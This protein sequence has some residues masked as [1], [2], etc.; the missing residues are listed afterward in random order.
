MISSAKRYGH[1]RNHKFKIYIKN[2]FLTYKFELFNS[3]I[4]L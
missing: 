2:I 3:S 4:N 1:M